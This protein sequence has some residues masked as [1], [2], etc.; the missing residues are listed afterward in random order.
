MPQRY[1]FDELSIGLGNSTKVQSPMIRRPLRGVFT[2]AAWHDF[3]KR[4]CDLLNEKH[5]LLNRAADMLEQFPPDP[6]RF[7]F[8]PAYE[9]AVKEHAEVLRL[10]RGKQNGAKSSRPVG[11]D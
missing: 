8:G 2:N 7:D 5:T 10:M 9:S 6:E 1:T 4:V 3:A 11:A